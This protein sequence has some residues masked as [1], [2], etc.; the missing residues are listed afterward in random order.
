M[1]ENLLLENKLI[2]LFIEGIDNIIDSNRDIFPE[3]LI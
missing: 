1:G 3:D 2:E